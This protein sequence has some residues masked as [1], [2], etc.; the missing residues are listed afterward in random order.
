MDSDFISARPSSSRHLKV[1]EMLRKA[2]SEIFLR[3]ESHVPELD[4]SSIT[5]SEV[6][7]SPD[8][9]NAT[10]YVMP[11][12]GGN[13]EAVMAALAENAPQIRRLLGRKVTI[14]FMPRIHYKLDT[15][16]EEAERIHRLL[17]EEE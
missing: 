3:G 17:K 15:S 2:L 11:L 1:G 5:V 4:N 16:F 6:R 13:K 7:V 9:K 10:A 8:L 14:K 12:A